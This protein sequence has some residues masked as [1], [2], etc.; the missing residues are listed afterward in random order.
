MLVREEALDT[1]F[2]QFH[3]AHK[4]KNWLKLSDLLQVT[5]VAAGRLES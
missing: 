2:F 3:F 5:E 4:K 1:Q